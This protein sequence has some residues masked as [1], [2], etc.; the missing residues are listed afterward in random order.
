MRFRKASR[1]MGFALAV[2]VALA[3]SANPAAAQEQDRQERQQQEQQ[4]QQQQM[5]QSQ[6]I[7]AKANATEQLS[8]FVRALNETGLKA[9]LEKEGPY[10][11]FA[12]SDEAFRQHFSEAELNRLLGEA[13]ASA[14]EMEEEGAREAAHTERQKLVRVL[15]AHVVMGEMASDRLQN[16]QQV[17]NLLGNT[18]AVSA[19]AQG[20]VRAETETQERE[21]KQEGEGQESG[22]QIEAAAQQQTQLQIGDATVVEADIQA[23][24]GVLYVID[25]VIEPEPR[26]EREQ[27]EKQEQEQDPYEPPAMN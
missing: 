6:T 14:G 16:V 19:G 5:Q 25:T 18:I 4:A 20:M 17:T 24:N 3:M 22:Q 21:Q 27:G 13:S 11:V 9:E 15:R 8:L 23:S 10:T 2:P 26:Q 7:V 12:P 1:A